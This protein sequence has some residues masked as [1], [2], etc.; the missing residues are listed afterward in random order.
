MIF[1]AFPGI[2]RFN[3]G[4]YFA[5]T[6]LIPFVMDLIASTNLFAERV[7]EISFLMGILITVLFY[8]E[9]K[10]CAVE[11]EKQEMLDHFLND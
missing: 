9:Y 4:K 11:I 10:K 1:A 8:F 7:Y 2:Q 3:A 5:V 6:L